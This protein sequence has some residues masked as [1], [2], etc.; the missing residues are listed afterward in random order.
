MDRRQLYLALHKLR[1][2]FGRAY[3]ASPATCPPVGGPTGGA[4]TGGGTDASPDFEHEVDVAI[5]AFRHAQANGAGAAPAASETVTGISN[6]EF[7]R[8]MQSDA[9]YDPQ[10]ANTWE[11]ERDVKE[12]DMDQRVETVKVP[13]VV[14]RGVIDRSKY[15]CWCCCAPARFT[16]CF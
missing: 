12:K 8:D 7:E 10:F 14:S 11:D 4:V 3:D 9:W 1:S 16:V 13:A 15:T 2:N 5:D 6:A